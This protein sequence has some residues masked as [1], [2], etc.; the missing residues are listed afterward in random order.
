[1]VAIGPQSPNAVT[2]RPATDTTAFGT[3]ETWATDCTAAGAADGTVL[4]ASFFNVIIAQLRTAI[5]NGSVT[6]DDTDDT[7]LWQA[8]QAAA[9][10]QYSG[11]AGVTISATGVVASNLGDA[12]LT[13]LND[14]TVDLATDTVIMWDASAGVHV[15]MTLYSA[16]KSALSGLSGATFTDATGKITFATPKYTIAATA[17]IG[18]VIQDKW[19][20]SANDILYMYISDGTSDF[21][22]EV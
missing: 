7:M 20:D 8:M 2:T 21:W 9:L 4:T 12:S 13:V 19:Y 10:S 3:S 11:G 1:M 16:I 5:S 6:L 15:E 17:P 22:R 18:P 14:T